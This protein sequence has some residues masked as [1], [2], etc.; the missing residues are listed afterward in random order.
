[1]P[2]TWWTTT[3]EVSSLKVWTLIIP[4]S[5]N[6]PGLDVDFAND[7]TNLSWVVT[8]GNDQWELEIPVQ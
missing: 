8:S 5:Q 2:R 4:R 1:M 7:E 3:N 6:L